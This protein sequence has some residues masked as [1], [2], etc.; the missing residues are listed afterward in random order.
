MS[1]EIV[2]VQSA[3]SLR[4]IADATDSSVDYLQSLNPELRRDTTPRG[5][6]YNVRVPAGKGKQLTALL[7]RVSPDR[8]DTARIV[9]IAPGEDLQSVANRTGVSVATLQAMNAGVD[10]KS[11]TQLIVPNNNVR[12]TN[13]RRGASATDTSSAP[14]LDKVRARKGDTIAKIA[15]AHKLSVDEVARLNGIA[16][17][18]ELQAG[19]E[20]K[21]PGATAAATSN[22]RR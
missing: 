5:E 2:P 17:N 22:R 18:A 9:S 21:L 12:L 14:S 8:R 16:P 11:A 3:T 20:I 15:A 7:K 1:Y 19:Q 13:W 6:A 4:L 10:L